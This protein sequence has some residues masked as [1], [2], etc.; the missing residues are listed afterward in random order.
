[1]CENL[2]LNRLLRAKAVAREVARV[3]QSTKGL[4]EARLLRQALERGAR[5]ETDERQ[6]KIAYG[7]QSVQGMLSSGQKGFRQPT[8]MTSLDLQNIF[9]ARQ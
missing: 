3:T 9:K 8:P 2:A 5:L 4:Q 1:M 6:G 7:I